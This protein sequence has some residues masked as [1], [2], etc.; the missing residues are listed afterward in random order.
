MASGEIIINKDVLDSKKHS[1][2]QCKSKF[3]GGAYNT[4]KTSYISTCSDEYVTVLKSKLDSKYK[5][6]QKGYQSIMD[7]WENYSCEVNSNEVTIASESDGLPVSQVVDFAALQISLSLLG[8]SGNSTS[9]NVLYKNTQLN[10][11]DDY[12]KID[13]SKKEEKETLW[14]LLKKLKDGKINGD[15]FL[16]GYVDSR[17]TRLEDVVESNEKSKQNIKDMNDE[18][19]KKC[20]EKEEAKNKKKTGMVV[21]GIGEAV[22]SIAAAADSSIKKVDSSGSKNTSKSSTSTK[23]SSSSSGSASSSGSTSASISASTTDADSVNKV[24]QSTSN[25]TGTTSDSN[26]GNVSDNVN[27]TDGNKSNIT[28]ENGQNTGG[29]NASNGSN[30]G[31]ISDN[32]NNTD[33]DKSNITNGTNSGTSGTDIGNGNVTED[34]LKTK[35]DKAIN[36]Y[37]TT[38]TSEVLPSLNYNEFE[39]IIKELKEIGLADDEIT[40]AVVE[41]MKAKYY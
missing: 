14:T 30:S 19:L 4:F 9:S 21:S 40:Q 8:N 26:Q 34:L 28:N 12:V 25:T 13:T 16:Q 24:E 10:S 35:I 7:W 1:F 22:K 32:V 27:N 20:K 3:E 23:S 2:N 5:K 6:I 17:F 18:M 37:N 29:N 41:I 36:D 31:T 39:D 15:Q 11:V 38:H 33:G